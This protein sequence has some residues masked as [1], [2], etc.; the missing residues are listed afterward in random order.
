M[1]RNETK[2]HVA[3]KNSSVLTGISQSD[4]VNWAKDKSI[5]GEVYC[6]DY[7]A[8]QQERKNQLD[9]LPEKTSL[10]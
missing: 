3:Q 10:I 1:N 4:V 2:Q 9:C 7:C 8:N 6:A 5:L